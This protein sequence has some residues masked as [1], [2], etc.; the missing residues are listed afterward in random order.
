MRHI[1]KIL[2]L[3]F[4]GTSVFGQGINPRTLEGTSIK[5]GIL[6]GNVKIYDEAIGDSVWLYTHD[7]LLVDTNQVRHLLNFV[8]N[9]SFS[10][11]GTPTRIPFFNTSSSLG[12]SPNLYWD[13]LNNRLGIYTATPTY[14]LDVNGG[15]A[16][17]NG[18]RFGIGGGNVSS[19]VVAGPG[20]LAANTTGGFNVAIGAL[21][22]KSNT[23]GKFNTGIGNQTLEA[24]TTGEFNT[25][26][27]SNALISNIS[28]SHNAGIGLNA[29]LWNATGNN[30]VGIASY[31]MYSNTSGTNNVGIA[32]QSLYKNTTGNDNVGIGSQSGYNNTTGIRNVS[33]GAQSLLGNTLSSNNVAIGYRAI[34]GNSGGYNVAVG[35]QSLFNPSGSS[36]SNSALGANSLQNS[37]GNNNTGIGRYSLYNLQTGGNNTAIGMYSGYGVNGASTGNV[38]V[39]YYSGYPETGVSSNKLYIVNNT[40]NNGIIGDFS[41]SKF[42]VNVAA[43]S[44]ARTWDVGGDVRIRTLNS[45]VPTKLTGST[46]SGDIGDITLGSGLSLSSGTLS[47]TGGSGT[48]TSVGIANGGGLSV[49]GSPITTSGVITITADDTSPTNELNHSIAWNDATDSLQI[50][51]AGGIK[52]VKITGFGTGNGTVTSVGVATGTTGT[53]VNVSGSPITTAGTITLNIP[54]AS[55]TNRGVLSTSDW[56][57]FNNKENAIAAGTTAQYWRGDKTWQTLNTSVVPEGSNLYF[58]NARA[59]TAISLTT[60]GTSG[61]ATYNS[62]TGVLNVPNYTFSGVTG[63]GINGRVAFWNGT[64]SLSHNYNLYWD[65]PNG[66]LGLGTTT[67]TARLDVDGAVRLR[68]SANTPTNIMGRDGSGYVANV[69]IGTG[70][71]LSGGTLTNTSLAPNTWADLSGNIVSWNSTGVFNS[72]KPVGIGDGSPTRLLDVNGDVR[73]RGRI[74]D[75]GNSSGS[76]GQVL[77]SYGAGNWGWSTPS[78]SI[79]NLSYNIK[80]GSDVYL[81]IS[82]GGAGVNLSDGKGIVLDRVA[83]NKTTFSA[84]LPYGSMRTTSDY[85]NTS[86]GSSEI[87]I[88]FSTSTTSQCNS[89]VTFNSSNNRL[90]VGTAGV[91][92]YRVSF[93]CDIVNQSTN[94]YTL[95]VY[96]RISGGSVIPASVVNK[97]VVTQSSVDIE[98]TFTKN[99]VINIPY[100]NDYIELFVKRV[101]GS[102]D[103]IIVKNVQLT[104]NFISIGGCGT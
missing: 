36:I 43:A 66:R 70:L 58:T 104:M 102:G 71:S 24:N 55:A 62:S 77:T 84:R 81:D 65:D 42:G 7:T 61:A 4:F 37:Q 40:G 14:R 9:H 91:G 67:P 18:V 64:S 60:S 100:N 56:T 99:F 39:G 17:I 74:Y 34:W 28:G 83:S 87:K 98:H 10:L 88:P 15:D 8:N 30:N 31:S 44:L 5:G 96:A 59:R 11:S 46:A 101:S 33:I 89:D 12:T 19:N 51:D 22:L 21:S 6:K 79:Q 103:K 49:S 78:G 20:A 41:T 29:L 45:V 75:S 57:T 38:F 2:I 3:L 48:V 69:S 93:E 73:F 90:I 27:A 63:S 82:G 86:V 26:I 47:A 16:L 68:T 35:A 92:M 80:S 72:G 95:E 94:D 76:S 25:A 1:L 52:R 23:T 53:D 85:T 13:T 50:V 97:K 54:T 32:Y